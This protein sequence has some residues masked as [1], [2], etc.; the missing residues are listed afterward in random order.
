[1]VKK[2]IK[3]II[4]VIVAVIISLIL[5]YVF[6][7]KGKNMDYDENDIKQQIEKLLENDYRYYLLKNGNITLGE[8]SVTINDVEYYYVNEPWLNS[9]NDVQDIVFNTFSEKNATDKYNEITDK[10]SFIVYDNK[11]FVDASQKNDEELSPK[12]DTTK[13]TYRIIDEDTMIINLNGISIYTYLEDGSW[14]LNN[15]FYNFID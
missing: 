3:I 13:Y 4:C 5:I 8:G 15:S 7:I 14:K 2:I 9:E 10:Y 12:Y 1:M 11:L 6:F